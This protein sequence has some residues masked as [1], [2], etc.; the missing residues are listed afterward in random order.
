[1]SPSQALL[2]VAGGISVVHAA[3]ITMPSD[4]IVVM[5]VSSSL[6]VCTHTTIRRHIVRPSAGTSPLHTTI[7]RHIV[8]PSAGTSPLHTT[9]RRHIVH[10][11]AGTSPLHTTIR[12]HIVH[13]SAGT[14]PLH[15]TISLNKKSKTSCPLGE[16]G[17][18]V[19]ERR[20]LYHKWLYFN[21]GVQNIKDEKSDTLVSISL[22]RAN[23]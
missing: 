16:S 15:T 6:S 1:M 13:P 22:N 23:Y 11:S 20:S 7:R 19:F 21:I 8:R 10:P 18:C 4:C 17:Q 9:I 2:V 5:S 14:S 3:P 12:R